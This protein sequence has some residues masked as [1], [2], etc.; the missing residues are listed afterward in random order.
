MTTDKKHVMVTI[1]DG[2]L[3]QAAEVV[4]KL[5]KAGLTNVQQLK[6]IGVVT[7]Q[8]LPSKI[9]AIK[10]IPGVRAVEDSAWIQ[11]PPPDSPIQ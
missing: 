9:E 3:E 8:A 6:T 7:G 1:D 4:R 11:L 2:Y 5:K 10:N